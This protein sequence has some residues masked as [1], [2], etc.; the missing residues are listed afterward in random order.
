MERAS[1]ADG[2]ALGAI[3]PCSSM[4][5]PLRRTFPTAAAFDTAW[6]APSEGTTDDRR[7]AE[8]ASRVADG[9][10]RKGFRLFH[11]GGLPQLDRRIGEVR[12]EILF[13][14][15]PHSD[16]F[17]VRFHLTHEG[18]GAV[19]ARFWRPSVRAPKTVAAGEV[20]LLERDPVYALWSSAEPAGA[21]EAVSGLIV[22]RLLPWFDLVDDP[23][24]LRDA[25]VEGTVP[26]IDLTTAV[27]IMLAEFGVREARRFIRSVAE[28]AWPP[29]VVP[30]PEGFALDE[31]RMASVVAYYQL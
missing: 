20:S 23:P 24:R 17:A 19:R 30:K 28:L 5:P 8:I 1:V 9:L 21:A 18:V 22:D 26:M 14:T 3:I 31:T 27:E 7:V 29:L 6:R 13:P 16:E 2:A 10:G 15:R 4:V 11:N 25:L 12:A